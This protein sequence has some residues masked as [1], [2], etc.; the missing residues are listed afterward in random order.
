MKI[1]L[2]LNWII[3]LLIIFVLSS[4]NIKKDD[5]LKNIEL[6]ENHIAYYNN[7]SFFYD[8]AWY[9]CSYTKVNKDSKDVEKTTKYIIGK[10][11][12]NNGFI[13]SCNTLYFEKKSVIQKFNSNVIENNNE[14]LILKNGIAYYID[15]GLDQDYKIVNNLESVIV[16]FSLD[17]FYERTKE[18][19]QNSKFINVDVIDYRRLVVEYSYLSSEL[20]YYVSEEYV[21]DQQMKIIQIVKSIVCDK[22]QEIYMFNEYDRQIFSNYVFVPNN[23]LEK[24][25]LVDDDIK[26][27]F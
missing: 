10:F 21:F 23:V 20:N 26:I 6:F 22:Y 27:D 1:S 25:I 4:C 16:Q 7:D 2:K 18:L 8:D 15:L 24:I 5:S 17:N 13:C 14:K 19:K 9:E 11:E 12:F 3:V